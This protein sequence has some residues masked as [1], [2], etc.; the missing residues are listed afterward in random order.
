M[1]FDVPDADEQQYLIIDSITVIM[2]PSTNVLARI[3]E[4][5][6]WPLCNGL[7]GGTLP[8]IWKFSRVTDRHKSCN[9]TWNM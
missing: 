8:V 6:E 4:M 9:E 2:M 3:R 1:L 7:T 5:I